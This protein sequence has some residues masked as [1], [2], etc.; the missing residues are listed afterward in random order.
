MH[1]PFHQQN[2]PNDTPARRNTAQVDSYER[3]IE[4]CEAKEVAGEVA[5]DDGDDRPLEERRKERRECLDMLKRELQRIKDGG[6]PYDFDYLLDEEEKR[7]MT[8][9]EE[10]VAKDTDEEAGD[11]KEDKGDEKLIGKD[12]QELGVKPEVKKQQ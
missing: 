1:S 5:K 8:E 7:L 4:E 12:K 9:C 11:E 3:Y 10:E 2:A 6:D